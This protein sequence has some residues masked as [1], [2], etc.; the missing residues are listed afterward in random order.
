MTTQNKTRTKKVKIKAL[1]AKFD[2]IHSRIVKKY[3]VYGIGYLNEL[4]A[5][6]DRYEAAIKKLKSSTL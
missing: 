3:P 5:M 6:L 1:D 2:R 4:H